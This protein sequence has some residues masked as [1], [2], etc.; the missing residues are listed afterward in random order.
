MVLVTLLLVNVLVL[1]VSRH[2]ALL[3]SAGI[4]RKTCLT[5]RVGHQVW[6]G[7]RRVNLLLLISEQVVWLFFA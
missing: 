7:A 4:V 5:V 6:Y 2:L 3:L 1:L